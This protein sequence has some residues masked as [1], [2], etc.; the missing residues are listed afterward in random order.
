MILPKLAR[1]R[2]T[3]IKGGPFKDF[4]LLSDHVVTELRILGAIPNEA[5]ALPGKN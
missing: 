5:F 4:V 1:R 3:Y 2:T